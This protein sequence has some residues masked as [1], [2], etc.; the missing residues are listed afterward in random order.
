M[1]AVIGIVGAL[2]WIGLLIIVLRW[3]ARIKWGEPIFMGFW[4]LSFA[5][6]FVAAIHF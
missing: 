4:V 1:E 5:A 3:T 6:L 2:L